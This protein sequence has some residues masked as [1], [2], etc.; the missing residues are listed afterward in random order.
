MGHHQL[1]AGLDEQMGRTQIPVQELDA[2]GVFKRFCEFE[3]QR[4]NLRRLE[5]ARAALR[6]HTLQGATFHAVHRDRQPVRPL[7]QIKNPRDTGMN[8]PALPPHLLTQCPEGAAVFEQGTGHKMEGDRLGQRPVKRV[9]YELLPR[10]PQAT[11]Q[12]VGCARQVLAG[13]K[14]G[15]QRFNDRAGAGF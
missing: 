10:E 9:P 5:T 7:H 15:E 2:V 4:L 3:K 12:F 1:P 6:Q 11:L 14:L 13:Q 8:E